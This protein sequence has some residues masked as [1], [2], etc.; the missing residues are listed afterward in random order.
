MFQKKIGENLYGDDLL[1]LLRENCDG[2]ED[3]HEYLVVFT[4]HELEIFKDQL[5]EVSIKI[6]DIEEAKKDV[7]AKFKA[8]IDPFKIQKNDLI[9]NLKEGQRVIRETCFMVRDE[10]NQRVGYY[11]ANGDLVDEQPMTEEQKQGRID[12]N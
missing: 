10:E 3:E 7:V 11:N 12:F 1:N 2:I 6:K 9:E 5:S 8:E 4:A